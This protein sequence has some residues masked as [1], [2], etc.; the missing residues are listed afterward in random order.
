MFADDTN[1]FHSDKNINNLFKIFNQELGIIRSWFNANKLSLN[2][3]KTKYTFFHS[4]SYKDR[5]P[6][7]LPRLEINS[8][9]IK[10]ESKITFL[11][12]LLDENLTWKDHINCV[13]NKVSKNIGLLYKARFLL[14]EKCPKQLYFSFIYSY[15]NYA[16]ITW[17]S[18]HKSKLKGL[19]RKKKHASR[20]MYFKDKYT[21]AEPLMQKMKTLNIFQ[22]N[23]SKIL[24][25]MHK[26]RNN[27]IPNVFKK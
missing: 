2:I 14:D 27:N 7:R 8:S 23:I 18:T 19:L 5:I 3:T 13:E 24:L 20:I 11:G 22:L 21:H 17:A 9:T 4:A 1:F 26:V 12:V 15:L 16:N 10:R 25:F 6:L